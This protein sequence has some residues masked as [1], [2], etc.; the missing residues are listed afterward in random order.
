MLPLLL[1]L[2]L[3]R[4]LLLLIEVGLVS[5]M[6]IQ[7]SSSSMSHILRSL[8]R[9]ACWLE[10]PLVLM[11]LDAPSDSRNASTK[12]STFVLEGK[13]R[14]EKRREEERRGEERRE[15]KRRGEKRRGEKR[16]GPA[17]LARIG[18][19]FSK[20]YT[21]EPWYYTIGLPS[22]PTTALVLP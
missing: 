5:V 20:R 11:P 12:S 6:S 2:L 17:G 22:T 19:G 14:K 21:T 3:L 1:L 9:M 13:R 16:S 7:S 18:I 15:E 4:L 8:R 10:E